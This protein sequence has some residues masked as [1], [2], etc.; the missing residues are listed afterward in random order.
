MATHNYTR[1]IQGENYVIEALADEPLLE[2]GADRFTMTAYGGSIKTGDFILLQQQGKKVCYLVEQ[3]DY[4]CDQ[5]DLWIARLV[6][7]P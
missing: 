3:I 2:D 7:K 4:Y 6:R 5:P 1:Q